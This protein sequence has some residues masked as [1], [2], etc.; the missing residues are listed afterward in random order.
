MH[1]VCP[2]CQNPVDVADENLSDVVL[3][4]ACGSNFGIGNQLGPTI[5]APRGAGSLGK[6]NLLE[7]V[8][9]G[10]FGTVYKARDRELDRTVA[11]KV[12][13]SGSF[14]NQ[15]E[16][17]RFLREARSV[18]Q[19]RHPSIVSVYEVGQS[20]GTPY[21]VSE[22]VEGMTLSDYLTGAKPS[23]RD[24][25]ELVAKVADALQYAHAHGVVHRD[26]KPSNIMLGAD[27]TPHV[28]D[29]GLARRD[30]GDATMTT[31]GQV[32]GTPAYMSPEQ[33]KGESHSVDGRG[34]V[35]S[36]GVIL[37]QLLTG[38]LPFRGN[39]RMLL[40]QVLHDEPRPPRKIND[41]VPRDLET[42]CLKSLAKESGRRYQ[43]AGEF[44]DDL[45]RYLKNE[46]IQ[47]RP[48]SRVE[49]TWRW[50][51]RN[52]TTA[53]LV[54]I[55]ALLLAGSSVGGYGM[56]YRE[57][58]SANNERTARTAAQAAE[59]RAHDKAD[60]ADKARIEEA[61]AKRAAQ[62]SEQEAVAAKVAAEESERES[63]NRLVRFLTTNGMNAASQGDS[64]GALPLLAEALR[65]D[66]DD[67]D[68]E[69]MHRR[70]LGA[71][72]RD[73]PYLAQ[74]VYVSDGNIDAH[75]SPDAWRV[76]SWNGGATRA[77]ILNLRSGRR[78]GQP[79]VDTS[80][81]TKAGFSPDGSRIASTHGPTVRIWS[82]A[83]GL[84]VGAPF[85]HISRSDIAFSPDGTRLATADTEQTARIWD[86]E[87]GQP[88][89]E[90]LPHKSPISKLQFSPD[91]KRLV[92]A[93]YQMVRVWNAES[94]ELIYS[95]PQQFG[96]V[97]GLAPLS[98]DG[99]TLA[100]LQGQNAIQIRDGTTGAPR[101]PTIKSGENMAIAKFSPDSH[102]LATASG[103][104]LRIW[105]V[106][107][108]A[109]I[110]PPIVQRDETFDFAFS[111]DS[112]RIAV[113]CYDGTVRAWDA[114][115]GLAASPVFQGVVHAHLA[116]QFTPDGEY[117]LTPTGFGILRLWDLTPDS[118]ASG[119]PASEGRLLARSS[120]GNVAIYTAGANGAR[121][122]HSVESRFISPPLTHSGSVVCAAFSPNGLLVVTGGDDHQAR[123]WDV[124]TGAPVT[125]PLQHDGLVESAVWTPNGRF[126]V[127]R[128]L[129]AT[130]Q[131][132]K[133]VWEAASG[134]AV[135][136]G[137]PDDSSA[138]WL[139]L[140]SP[141]S[142]VVVALDDQHRL[143]ILDLA[144]LKPLTGPLEGGNPAF[145]PDG[146]RFAYTDNATGSVQLLETEHWRPVADLV[147]KPGYASLEFRFS[148]T[149][150]RLVTIDEGPA[151]EGLVLVWDSRTGA[152]IA[153]I[154]NEGEYS[155]FRHVEISPQGRH[156][157]TAD[158]RNT[159]QVWDAETGTAISPSFSL[160]R[161]VIAVS[162]SGDGRRIITLSGVTVS[163]V[164]QEWDAATGEAVTPPRVWGAN[165]Q[166]MP[167]G[168]EGQPGVHP[169]QSLAATLPVDE[170][171][172]LTRLLS[173]RHVGPRGGILY[174]S[175]AQ[176][177]RLWQEF[178]TN[179]PEAFF[180][181]KKAAEFRRVARLRAEQ[182]QAAAAA[183][184]AGKIPEAIDALSR[185][186][187][188][189]NEDPALF[190]RRANLFARQRQW[191][192]ADAD[193]ERAEKLGS[194][195]DTW[196]A[197]GSTLL[198]RGDPER[199]LAEFTRVL[200][201]GVSPQLVTRAHNLRGESLAEL[202]KWSEA[203]S[204]FGHVVAAAPTS[205]YD[206]KNKA[207][208]EVAAR[209]L[210]AWRAT[211]A[212]ADRAL[213]AVK[214]DYSWNELVA[215]CCLAPDS[216]VN[217]AG[218]I[219]IAEERVA[220]QPENVQYL[221]RLASA[222]Y[223]GGQPDRALGRL[224][225]LYSGRRVL[226]DASVLLSLA[227]VHHRLGHAAEAQIF[228]ERGARL[229]AM[230][231]ESARGR[232]PKA[233]ALYWLPMD[234]LLREAVQDVPQPAESVEPVRAVA[235][236]EMSGRISDALAPLGRLRELY[237]DDAALALHRGAS[238]SAMR[239]WNDA[240]A[241]FDSAEKLG[242]TVSV[243]N[244]RGLSLLARGEPER[245]VTEC[246]RVLEAGADSSS[247]LKARQ[248]RGMA[249][250][251]L[252]RWEEARTE[253]VRATELAP[254]SIIDWEW[255]GLVELAGGNSAAWRETCATLIRRLAEP[256]AVWIHDRVVV[257]CSRG[258]D[259]GVDWKSLVTIAEQEL[260]KLKKNDGR[261]SPFRRTLGAALYRAG[262]FEGAIRR[263]RE[264]A[265][266]QGNVWDAEAMLYLAMAHQRLDHADEARDWLSKATAS[267]KSG[268]Q[269][270]VLPEQMLM[271]LPYRLALDM[272]HRE[273]RVLIEEK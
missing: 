150:D 237:P 94:G 161:T 55:I 21:L 206:W 40:H 195:V 122:W 149:L 2:H 257:I 222:Y 129:T 8:G 155:L 31:D 54:A 60:E 209:D 120:E 180:R 32:L 102:R 226:N 108:G 27:H 192:E 48:V 158:D 269:S 245:A 144:S 103:T 52:P 35:Y 75:L 62:Q 138:K 174:D 113:T 263:M 234:L 89:T 24:S 187:E 205:I 10:A 57:A 211:C 77:S 69:A 112:R 143:K 184:S 73:V 72:L 254:Q 256:N 264:T 123:V 163:Q 258:A 244:A 107:S 109:T 248:T 167:P 162:F 33:A 231:K 230:Q 1:L 58:R 80:R 272:L 239:R 233:P 100:V 126:F 43:S 232:Q 177:D 134:R 26:I 101:G 253:F 186:V 88:V 79:L 175:P 128:T 247:L 38:E 96:Y 106:Q 16:Q 151:S 198:S 146:T 116:P 20:D 127:T 137:L 59:K 44:G 121:V 190:L 251:K 46:P 85:P 19:L 200:D 51:R 227:L 223:R 111:P 37:Y 238:L 215:I 265:D 50:C 97:L 261:E 6:F 78:V 204:E 115:T 28:M 193:F 224:Q 216:G 13:R 66:Q 228:L 93:S 243:W 39:T 273:A 169:L 168:A 164:Y 140:I 61:A 22:F 166:A 30:A 114:A 45:R 214:T 131:W 219:K 71:V 221:Q 56:A 262:E 176:A 9:S 47:A 139:P 110:G 207:L 172:M 125:A 142:R 130:G 197:R 147:Q 255:K 217:A 119:P 15:D 82:S 124:S 153:T 236:A 212:A 74:Q 220:G 199:A 11:I 86:I 63:R 252:E 34:D 98:P 118:E 41:L 3:C 92:S 148:R 104:T 29:F 156:V 266:P 18:A 14:S 49:R 157:V 259:A 189:D 152:R 260:A 12:P 105:D 179:H 81:F 154:Q 170:L 83:T 53:G 240:D 235:T 241:D 25:A 208:C 229:I 132:R 182:T 99:R 42:I 203:A 90:P 23:A 196:M 7:G 64:L 4:S 133:S 202:G 91:G 84:P 249:L 173:L 159:V 213:S 210:S 183:D 141:H 95:V 185:L 201:S 242:E 194:T 271:V 181:S 70:R 171:T 246:G 117:L 65:L 68:R 67:D 270:Y 225:E 250:A 5:A 267:I 165:A 136:S 135:M 36:L 145:N 218:L 17:E 188:V 178:A 268:R 76:V 160:T 191:A 87:T